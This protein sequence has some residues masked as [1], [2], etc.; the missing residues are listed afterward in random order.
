MVK[1]DWGTQIAGLQI[2]MHVRA[3]SHEHRYPTKGNLITTVVL[4]WVV[5]NQGG[6]VTNR[7]VAYKS[8]IRWM[9]GWLTLPVGQTGT[10]VDSI[11]LLAMVQNLEFRRVSHLIFLK[12]P[13]TVGNVDIGKWHFGKGTAIYLLQINWARTSHHLSWLVCHY[14]WWKTQKEVKF[15]FSEICLQH[16]FFMKL[17]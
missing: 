15:L 4:Q 11:V 6:K 7:R 14:M 10:A 2:Y 12:L 9:E 1:Y 13:L 3:D 17:H 8:W 5:C 16:Q